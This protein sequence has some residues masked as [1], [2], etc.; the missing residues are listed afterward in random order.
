MRAVLEQN[1]LPHQEGAGDFGAV[2]S[3]ADL[4]SDAVLIRLIRAAAALNAAGVPARAAPRA[5]KPRAVPPDLAKALKSHAAA[6]RTFEAFTASQRREYVD[7]I[8]EAKREA[9]RSQRLA[10]TLRWL[11]EGKKRNWKYAA[12]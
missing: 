10:T 12:C 1:G 2:R 4:P 8:T 9:T 3:R 11:A 7:W 5:K 6:A